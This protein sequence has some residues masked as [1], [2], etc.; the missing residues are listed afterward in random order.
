[1]EI[2][3]KLEKTENRL[4]QL[5]QGAW[6]HKLPI[7]LLLLLSIIIQISIGFMNVNSSMVNHYQAIELNENNFNYHINTEGF[8]SGM[9]LVV[10]QFENKKELTK[11]VVE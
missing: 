8:K 10:I 11:F 5:Q 4:E 3:E 2:S 7:I 1:M 6:Q 9:Y